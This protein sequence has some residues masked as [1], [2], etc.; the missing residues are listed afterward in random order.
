M[1][2]GAVRPE[3]LIQRGTRRPQLDGRLGVG[4]RRLDLAPVTDD[5]GVAEQP[6]DVPIVEAGNP[7]R[8]EPLECAAERL[9]LPQDR[10]PRETR[11]EA[12]ETEALVDALLG[13]DRAAPLLVVVG[14]V[15]RIGR[16]PAALQLSSTSTITMPSSTVTG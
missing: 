6:L 3:E 13:R 15:E 14:V 10:D 11:L 5:R 16:L 9:P 12:L 8:V 7:L 4:D 1:R 2:L